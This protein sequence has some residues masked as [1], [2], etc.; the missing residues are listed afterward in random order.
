MIDSL[1]EGFKEPYKR[2]V[3]NS[4]K[5]QICM[6]KIVMKKETILEKWLLAIKYFFHK[7]EK[8]TNK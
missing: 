3:Q 6:A 5:L 1:Q 2:E 7:G 4:A 8:N